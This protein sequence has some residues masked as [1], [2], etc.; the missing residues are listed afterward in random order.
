VPN[1][2]MESR[3]LR[4]QL[5]SQLGQGIRDTEQVLSQYR[6][7]YPSFDLVDWP[8]VQQ[9]LAG[10]P[11]PGVNVHPEAEGPRS[12]AW[13]E[14]QTIEPIPLGSMADPVS[15]AAFLLAPVA[16]R[17]VRDVFGVPS[18]PGPPVALVAPERGEQLQRVVNKY[19]SQTIP[20]PD[21][22]AR[23]SQE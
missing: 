20:T 8:A 10:Q 7:A 11:V 6:A 19:V 23:R 17:G 12:P 14:E 9:H 3:A 5:R 21:V 4:Q 1:G 15:Q 22:P 16:F 18:P 13:I 2:S